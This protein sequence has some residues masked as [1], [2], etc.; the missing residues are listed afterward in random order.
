MAETVAPA[1]WW[2]PGSIGV[3]AVISVDFVMDWVGGAPRL[4]LALEFAAVIFLIALARGL[5][6][7]RGMEIHA[8][9]SDVARLEEE[10]KSWREEAHA[11][12]RG[13]GEALEQQFA[14]WGLTRAES[15]VA[16]LLLKGLSLKEVAA[17]RGTSERTTRDQARAVYRKGGL[18]GRSELSAFFL[19]DLLLPADQR[20]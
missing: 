19:E 10:A 8:L 6:R 9:Q 16:L 11:A 2:L 7:R 4:H 20:A 17:V 18:S 14:R 3:M 15:E 5:Y 12:L 13:L 1:R